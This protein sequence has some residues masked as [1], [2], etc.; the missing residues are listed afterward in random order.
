MGCPTWRI[1]ELKVAGHKLLALSARQQIVIGVHRKP[2]LD[3]RDVI[4]GDL[5]ETS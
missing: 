1:G 3:H 5:V 4:Y 2:P